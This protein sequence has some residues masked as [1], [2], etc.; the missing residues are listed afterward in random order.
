MDS[1]LRRLYWQ[2]RRGMLELDLVLSPFAEKQL[3]QLDINDIERYSKLLDCED[4]DL[5]GYF[6]ERVDPED[7][8][9]LRI[10]QLVRDYT[11]AKK[12]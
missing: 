12:A 7:P 3:P 6:L 1:E 4:Q 10:V 5:F 9:L 8:D 2:S 11:K